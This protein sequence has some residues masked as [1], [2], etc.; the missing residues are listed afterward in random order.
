[1]PLEIKDVDQIFY[2]KRLADFLPENIIDIHTHIWL[3]EHL[4]S[5]RQDSSRLAAWPSKIA[6]VNQVEDLIETYKRM[7]PG[8]NVTPLIFGN[9][10]VCENIDNANAYVR[11]VSEEHNIP[12][13]I[14]SHP[15]WSNSELEEKI[16][17]GNFLGV[18]PYLSYAAASIPAEE[19]GIYDF[20]PHHQLEMLNKHSL[21]VMLHIP[22][23]A[24]LKDTVNLFQMNQIEKQYP[25]IK[26]IIAHV[27]RAYCLEDVGDAFG[28][29]SETKNM[30]FDFSA[31]TN[32]RVFEE[33][34][35]TVGPKRI[36]FGSDLPITKMRMQRVCEDGIY[37][38]IVPKGIYGDV[39]KDKHMREVAGSQAEKLT[40]FMY[41][42]IDAFR[43]AAM[44]T[45]LTKNTIEDVF[46]NNAVRLIKSAKGGLEQH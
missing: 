43:H 16:F 2:Q 7:F 4:S 24:R 25:K 23:A 34:I 44:T 15:Q 30:M 35:K 19:I 14:L 37:I 13:L 5:S 22:R 20:L 32:T 11:K 17:T 18:K 3:K 26:L 41:E 33:L 45:G 27:G 46:Y 29:L 12:S 21:I 38:N 39:S 36:M 31:N 6:K 10:T 28:V 1:M 9:P 40:F 8:K 42:E